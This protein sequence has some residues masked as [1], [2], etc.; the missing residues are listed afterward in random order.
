MSGRIENV[1]II[2]DP[3]FYML[4]IPLVVLFGMGKGGLGPGIV[5]IAVPVLSFV[6]HPVQ[7]AAILLPILCLAD[8]F[9]VYHF[10]KTF[11]VH[12]LKILIP[13]GI[14]GIF[15]AFLIMDRLDKDMLRALTGITAILFCLDH[16]FRP[17]TSKA[18]RFGRLGGMFWG[19]VAGFTS[20]Q[21]HAGAAPVS[22]YLFPQKLDKVMLMG[23]M[24]I[25]FTVMNYV[26]LVP[27]SMMGFLSME[28]ILTS[29]IL[30]PLAPVGVKLGNI[31]LHTLDQKIIYRFLYVI[32]FISGLKLCWDGLV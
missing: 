9:A 23:T 24:A 22:V 11:A 21:I 1:N 25:F 27:Y 13:A 28:N 6:I 10:R 31:V 19:A 5:T 20:T 32:L 18:L 29:L 2:Q 30:M 7:A 8:L 12:H 14:A 3:I 17:D 4:A 26:K 16:W 15:I